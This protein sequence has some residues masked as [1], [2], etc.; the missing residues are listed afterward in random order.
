V[1][2]RYLPNSILM[3]ADQGAGQQALGRSLPFLRNMRPKNGKATAYVCQN[4]LCN[5]P[6][7]DPK[8]VAR[9][10]DGEPPRQ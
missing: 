2:G 3:L 5:L 10:L 8:V 6:S 7:S 9:L 1:W 4:Y